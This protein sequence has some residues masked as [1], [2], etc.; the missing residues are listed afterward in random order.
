MH[1]KWFRLS[2]LFLGFSEVFTRFGG[3]GLIVIFIYLFI[4]L[5]IDR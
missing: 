3:G 1:K 2:F 4:Y 5:F